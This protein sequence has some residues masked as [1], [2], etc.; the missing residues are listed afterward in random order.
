MNET[1]KIEKEIKDALTE[2]L[3]RNGITEIIR[4]SITKETGKARG[5][6]GGIGDGQLISEQPLHDVI[7]RQFT[8]R[9]LY[10]QE[11][12]SL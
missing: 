11:E 12:K 10:A 7:L 2:V 3:N 6:G 5:G 9:V 8:I 1:K 4:V